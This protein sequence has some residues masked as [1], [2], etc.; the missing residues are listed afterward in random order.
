M[1]MRNR[2]LAITRGSIPYVPELRPIAGSVTAT[3]LMQQ[4][5]YWFER[6]PEG[7]YKFQDTSPDN[8]AYKHGDS[9][10]EELSFSVAEFRSAFDQIGHRHKSKTEWN[11]A[12][13]PFN[14][15]F[16][17]CYTDRRSRLT[18][19]FRNH[20]MVDAALD[21]LVRKQE[22]AT[23][24]PTSPVRPPVHAKSAGNTP[25]S[26]AKPTDFTV[27]SDSPSTGNALSQLPV[28]KDSQFPVNSTSEHTVDLIS[29]LSQVNNSNS[30]EVESLNS[31][32]TEN[33]LLQKTTQRPQ[34]QLPAEF[35]DNK[36]DASKR[37]SCSLDIQFENL[38]FPKAEPLELKHLADLVAGCRPENRQAV[39]D[40]VEGSRQRGSLRVGIVPFARAL[41]KAEGSGLFSP[42]AGVSVRAARELSLQ[43]ALNTG[44]S[45]LDEAT[46]SDAH[47]Q[48]SPHNWTQAEIDMLPPMM[49]ERV[50]VKMQQGSQSPPQAH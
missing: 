18:F 1:V 31:A 30:P 47:G 24:A 7:F 3:V 34:Q 50:L 23:P 39:L 8:P 17:C 12:T 36:I 44:A 38:V 11:E 9:W 48:E 49:R 27:S 22:M 26:G 33:T 19:Y 21:A 45:A 41:C 4:L 13:D 14:G 46:G 5:D 6:Q 32:Y 37:G 42:S 10:A 29:S 35:S 15:K 28:S 2:I 16:Y 20:A 25:V 43:H 40:E